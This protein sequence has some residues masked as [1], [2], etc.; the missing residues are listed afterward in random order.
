MNRKTRLILAVIITLVLAVAA[1]TV[2]AGSKEGS[3][4]GKI[5]DGHGACNGGAINMG[6][7]TFTMTVGDKIICNFEV[8]RTKVPN[9][10]MSGA[11]EGLEFRSDGFI[12]TGGP[13]DGIGMLEVCFAY[14]PQDEARNAQIYAV[15]GSQQTI[16]PA[17]K[18]GTPAQLCAGTP[19]L[20]GTFAMVGTP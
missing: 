6:D 10:F 19:I 16:L 4:P 9:V 18:E 7:A 17:V 1:T 14:S 15:F 8:T 3:V 2:W 11:P 20:N 12:V 5:H 13:V